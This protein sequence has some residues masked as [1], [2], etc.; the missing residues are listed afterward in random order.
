[1]SKTATPH[2]FPRLGADAV[3]PKPQPTMADLIL[4]IARSMVKSSSPVRAT[5]VAAVFPTLDQ[6]PKFEKK[7]VIPDPV[8]VE[9]PEPVFD[10]GPELEEL[11]AQAREEGHLEGL[12]AGRTAGH[13]E[14]FAEGFVEGQAQGYA[15]ARAELLQQE[16]AQIAAFG[17]ALQA[18]V[19][20]LNATIAD[21][22]ATREQAMTDM[23]M[24]VVRGILSAELQISRQSALAIVQEALSE[25][26]HGSH[27]RIRMNPFDVPIV[28]GRNAELVA[29]SSSLRDIDLVED[30][31]LLGGCVV[32][33]EGGVVDA[34]ID[35]RLVLVEQAWREAA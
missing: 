32:E 21:W 10:P 26:T 19:D 25:I 11:R 24:Q 4:P 18:K 8:D 2:S 15:Q 6:L 3:A 1:M 7:V 33:T 17:E 20:D 16:S 13:E 34:S 5:P 28:Q 9:E 22:Y 30:R 12:E 29:A 31:S 35:T 14:G 23:A 27:A